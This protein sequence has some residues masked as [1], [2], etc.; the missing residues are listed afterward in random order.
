ML[1]PNSVYLNGDRHCLIIAL[2][3]MW[4]NERWI[5]A[6]SLIWHQVCVKKPC[7]SLRVRP[8]QNR[9]YVWVIFMV[10]VWMPEVFAVQDH[11][12]YPLTSTII[13]SW[14]A[15]KELPL[16]HHWSKTHTIKM[17]QKTIGSTSI[18]GLYYSEMSAVCSG[19]NKEAMYKR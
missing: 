18:T 1:V 6:V 9:Y 5:K 15:Y 7:S 17:L 2:D 11:N 3:F 14:W 12:H 4:A 13:S 16:G 10:G 19:R 8:R